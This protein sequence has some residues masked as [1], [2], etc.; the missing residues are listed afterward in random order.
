MKKL[1]LATAL[2]VTLSG[3]AISRGTQMSDAQINSIQRNVTTETQIRQM[4][5]EPVAVSR[6]SRTANKVITFEY[7]KQD[8][9]REMAA[10]GGGLLGGLLGHQIGGGS[11][12]VIARGVGAAGG[13]LVGGNVAVNREVNQTLTVYIDGS[14]RVSDYRVSESASRNQSIGVG[15]SVGGI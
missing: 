13:A 8:I 4:F 9:N 2:V 15:G 12:Q 14:G 6:D 3:C 5:G 11:G 1:A 10:V 7:K